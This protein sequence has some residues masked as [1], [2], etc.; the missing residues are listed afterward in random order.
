M[1]LLDFLLSVT[2]DEVKQKG[3]GTVK[4]NTMKALITGA[5]SGIGRDMAKVL[6]AKGCDLILVARRRDRLELLKQE[7]LRQEPHTSVQ[8]IS[9]DLSDAA[10][11][12]ALYEQVK[13]EKVDVLINNAG[14]GVFGTFD[15][16]DL[17]K[18]LTMLDTN[19]RAVHILTKLFLKDMKTRNSGYIL[20]VASSA[21]FMPGPLLSGYYASKAYVLRLTQAIYEELRRSGISVHVSALCPGPVN[22]EFNDVAQVKFGVKGLNSHDVAEYALKKMF[23]GKLVIIPGTMMKLARFFCRFVPDKPLLKITYGLQKRK[24]EK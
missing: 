24:D 17:Q 23:A 21:A 12:I 20:N 2:Y 4:E 11:C 22:T 13:Q 9:A 1:V 5:S 10:A 8:V 14:L 7:L 6:S 3:R 19:I 15:T 16:T 18:E